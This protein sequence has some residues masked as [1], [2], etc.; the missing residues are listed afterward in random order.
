MEDPGI[1]MA[2]VWHDN[3]L[4]EVE[5]IATNGRFAGGV[6][7]YAS[8]EIGADFADAL[9]GFPASSV[10]RRFFEI[11]TFDDGFA[12]GGARFDFRCADA[13]G[14]AIVVIRLRAAPERGT[15]ANAEFSLPLEAA[16]V[17]AFVG[18]LGRLGPSDSKVAK[19]RGGG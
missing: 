8:L 6:R 3:D 17:D 7:C 2:I 5:V 12:G 14:H 18:E 4:L 19:L 10:D 15:G 1:T 9:R 11:G 16:A 13:A